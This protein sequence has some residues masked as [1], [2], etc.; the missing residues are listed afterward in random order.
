MLNNPFFR[1]L[2]DLIFPPRCLGTGEIVSAQH[3]FSPDFWAE[4]DF[5]KAPK[6]VI[7]GYPLPYEV[8][9]QA[10][11]TSCLN[12]KPSFVKGGSVFVYNEAIAQLILPFKHGDQTEIAPTLAHWLAQ[13]C[14]ETY[15]QN[16]HAQIDYIIPVPLHK[17]RFWKRRYNQAAL[18]SKH[19]SKALNI[20]HI[21]DGITRHKK[22]IS[23]GSMKPDDR[24]KNVKNAFTIT[25]KY[26]ECLLGKNIL[27]IDDVYTSGATLHE[28]CHMLAIEAKIQTHILTLARAIKDGDL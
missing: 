14:H 8:G 27:V 23:Q 9:D 18:L 16:I 15:G 4:L 20:P 28:I 24:R 2:I 3:A 21:P 7:C 17:H 10:Q 5:I 22:T 12:K 1:G 26:K 25:D 19:L 11:C 13:Y 6:C